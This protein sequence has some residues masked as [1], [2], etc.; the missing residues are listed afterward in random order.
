MGS[1]IFCSPILPSPVP[2]RK[3]CDRKAAREGVGKEGKK[4]RFLLMLVVWEDSDTDHQPK[5]GIG[6]WRW[7][8]A[9]IQDGA[10]KRKGRNSAQEG[11]G[12]W[13]VF[14]LFFFTFSLQDCGCQW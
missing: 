11:N 9:S 14:S 5:E 6:C 2:A 4:N 13:F 12:S 8:Q 7:L 3:G 1:Q 10:A